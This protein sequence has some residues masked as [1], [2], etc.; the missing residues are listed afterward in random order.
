[1][2]IGM[3]IKNGFLTKIL[4]KNDLVLKNIIIE[5]HHYGY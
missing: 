2:L 1:M 4:K 5:R 3:E